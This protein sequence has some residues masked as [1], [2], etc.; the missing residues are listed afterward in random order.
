[1]YKTTI[2]VYK[3]SI[4]KKDFIS[5]KKYEMSSNLLVKGGGFEDI[6]TTDPQSSVKEYKNNVYVLPDDTIYEVM[7]KIQ[8]IA[9]IP[10]EFQY[11]IINNSIYSFSYTN[12]NTGVKIYPNPFEIPTNIVDEGHIHTEIPL[13][14]EDY[15]YNVVGKNPDEKI[16]NINV[17]PLDELIQLENISTQVSQIDSGSLT[18]FRK[19]LKY[20]YPYLPADKYS[21]LVKGSGIEFLEVNIKG[22]IDTLKQNLALSGI[23]KEAKTE[24]YILDMEIEMK[25]NNIEIELP[26]LFKLYEI[27]SKYFQYCSIYHNG[28]R[29]YKILNT[30]LAKNQLFVWNNIPLVSDNQLLAVVDGNIYYI[31]RFSNIRARIFNKERKK[32]IKTKINESNRMFI[33]HIKSYINQSR[34]KINDELKFI[35]KDYTLNN[36]NIILKIPLDNPLTASIFRK[37]ISNF[38]K[39]IVE[40]KDRYTKSTPNTIYGTYRRVSKNKIVSEYNDELVEGLPLTIDLYGDINIYIQD[41]KDYNSY[42]FIE[43]FFSKIAYFIDNYKKVNLGK[44]PI[45]ERIKRVLENMKISTEKTTSVN[46][47]GDVKKIKELFNIDP[48]LFNYYDYLSDIE[49]RKY[50]SYSRLVQKIKQPLPVF[51]DRDK[52]NIRK[53]PGFTYFLEIPNQ[54]YPGTINTYYC[55]DKEYKYP[56]FIHPKNHPK[57]KC[58]PICRKKPSNLNDGTKN[59]QIWEKC[60]AAMINKKTPTETETSPKDIDKIANPLYVK[61]FDENKEIGKNKYM[62]LPQPFESILN[63]N[64]VKNTVNVIDK[65]ICYVITPI[66]DINDIKGESSIILEYRENNYFLSLDKH[67]DI[68]K[69]TLKERDDITVILK[70]KG[71]RYFKIGMI[72]KTK[73]KYKYIERFD[74]KNLLVSTLIDV[75]N[76]RKNYENIIP[77]KI[78]TGQV[79]NVFDEKDKNEINYIEINNECLIPIQSQSPYKSIPFKKFYPSDANKVIHYMKKYFRQHLTEIYINLNNNKGYLIKFSNELMIYVKDFKVNGFNSKIII[80][81]T[82]GNIFMY[83]KGKDIKHK[84]YTE[85]LNHHLYNLAVMD[86]SKSLYSDKDTTIIRRI[87]AKMNDAYE[88]IKKEYSNVGD[89]IFLYND[90]KK[91]NDMNV[92]G[93]NPEHYNW[94]FS[95]KKIMSLLVH[96]KNKNTKEVRKIVSKEINTITNIKPTNVKNQEDI[97]IYKGCAGNNISPSFYCSK[98]GNKYTLNLNSVRQRNEIID[99][100]TYKLMDL[101]WERYKI[102]SGKIEKIPSQTHTGLFNE[103]NDSIIIDKI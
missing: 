22:Y 15:R 37:I 5:Q 82:Q 62:G 35:V 80:H 67:I 25:T 58:L 76:Q 9:N 61:A 27:D 13:T 31:D 46:K 44:S 50:K 28:K 24:K 95:Y 57:N 30:E 12:I 36:F 48:L 2:K 91:F 16:F 100:I 14:L 52:E 93:K 96:I 72:D 94:T 21:Q 74:K 63:K 75:F 71:N 55:P 56:G 4:S 73:K 78:I 87:F 59:S 20:Y 26:I 8:Y 84:A 64:C 88:K 103:S 86:F 33:N 3:Y 10:K 53:S 39:Y 45:L 54:T 51:T 17:I 81:E 66:E 60:M 99:M 77:Y 7:E 23:S 1:M 89:D 41:L 68:L 40:N 29:Y 47:K 38:D 83:K 34:V 43:K 101:P 19:V 18:F 102:L 79:G 69:K 98:H 92:Y 32:D 97:I 6:F 70:I 11:I 85:L 65:G 42:F 90:L 49:K